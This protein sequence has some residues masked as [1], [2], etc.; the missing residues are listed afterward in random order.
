MDRLLNYC[1]AQHWCL[2]LRL[3]AILSPGASF[4]PWVEVE[5]VD[6]PGRFLRHKRFLSASSGRCWL[7][8]LLLGDKIAHWHEEYS[9]SFSGASIKSVWVMIVNSSSPLWPA[10]WC[11]FASQLCI[12]PR[13]P[14]WN[15]CPAKRLS[16]ERPRLVSIPRCSSRLVRLCLESIWVFCFV[17]MVISNEL[18]AIE[19]DHYQ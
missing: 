2:R 13:L 4:Y 15:G 8:S 1:A 19:V 17:H 14:T 11:A 5:L 18:D 9:S 3:F 7:C 16:F 6:C 12:P 10:S